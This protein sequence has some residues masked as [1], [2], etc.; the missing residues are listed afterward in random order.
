MPAIAGMEPV[1]GGRAFVAGVVGGL[2]MSVAMAIARDLYGIPIRL[3]MIL[4]TLTGLSPGRG[5]FAV[6]LVMHLTLS[7]VVAILYGLGL[8]RAAHR[9]GVLPGLV[10]AIPHAIAGGLLVGAIPAVHP[11][12]PEEIVAPGPFFSYLGQGAVL[13]FVLAHALYGAIV[14]LGYGPVL[15]PARARLELPTFRRHTA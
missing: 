2:A 5:T 3:E 12:V 15:H 1:K 9:S 14:G 13:F 10:L 11:L 6:G 8:E 4:G 7:G